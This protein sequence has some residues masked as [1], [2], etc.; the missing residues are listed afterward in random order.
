MTR[1]PAT[2]DPREL[3]KGWD[4]ADAAADGWDAETLAAAARWVPVPVPDDAG[5][6]GPTEAGEETR[7]RLSLRASGRRDLLPKA[8]GA[9]GAGEGSPPVFVCPPFRVLAVTR[10][11]LGGEF[12]RSIEFRDLDGEPRREV[13]ADRERQGSGD[14]LRARLAAA[15]FEIAVHPEA[16]RLF[17]ELLRRWQ[18]EDRARSVTRTGWIGPAFVLPDRV[19]GE[20]DEPVLLAAEGER[21]AFATRGTLADWRGS[22]RLCAAEIPGSSSP[23]RSRSLRPLLRLTGAESGGFHLRG[24]PTNASSSGKT[25]AAGR[26]VGL[27]PAGLFATVAGHG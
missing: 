2:G 25:T 3:A 17:L 7:L 6:S 27:R 1:D 26:R 9:K 20:G 22:G 16:R 19:I 21:P 15:G 23:L 8:P 10:D 14:S 12:G 18:P 4:A 13:I 11:E 24:D 5:D